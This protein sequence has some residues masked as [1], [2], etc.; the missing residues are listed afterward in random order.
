[1]A[2]R[3]YARFGLTALVAVA[4]FGVGACFGQESEA[5]PPAKAE[6]AEKKAPRQD[7][8][9]AAFAIPYGTSLNAKQRAEYERLK[10][11]KESALR[12]A[13]MDLDAATTSAEKTELRREVNVLQR[14]IRTAIKQI[15]MMPYYEAWQKQL[16]TPG[17]SPYSQSGYYGNSYAAM[18]GGYG[19]GYYGYP[20]YGGSYPGY[21]WYFHHHHG[22]GNT[23]VNQ[24]VGTTVVTHKATGTVKAG[25]SAS[26]TAARSAAPPAPQAR[27]QNHPAKHR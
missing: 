12:E 8:V 25:S 7:P 16:A 26:P 23:I 20:W 6:K 11:D 4:G 24:P 2:C 9:A 19:N 13:I 27:P 5:T 14:E 22:H 18:P 1:M 21:Y 17:Y 3:E 15:L 10:T